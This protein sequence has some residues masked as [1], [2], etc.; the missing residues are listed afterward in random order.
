M[1]KACWQCVFPGTRPNIRH[2]IVFY[3][4]HCKL[5]NLEAVSAH[6][7]GIVL[8]KYRKGCGLSIKHSELGT[9]SL[10]LW[11]TQRW[12]GK[13]GSNVV[14]VV[15]QWQAARSLFILGLVRIACLN[16][17]LF[18]ALQST[19]IWHVLLDVDWVLRV[20]VTFS[21]DFYSRQ[22]KV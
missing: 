15:E 3:G 8:E 9:V 10:K 5:W 20:V 12:A 17:K 14:P 13:C 19:V 2:L 7:A 4:K 6:S 21:A 22:R 11:F 18:E 16:C 1:H